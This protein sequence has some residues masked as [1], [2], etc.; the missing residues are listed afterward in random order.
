MEIILVVMLIGIVSAVAIA[1]F[2]EI[3]KTRAVARNLTS[4]IRYA[5]EL[6][7]RLQTNC[8]VYFFSTTEYRV[9][10]NDSTGDLVKDPHTGA[11]FVV[12][13]DGQVSGVT[14]THDLG[15]AN[16]V[17]FNSLGT[18]LDGAGTPLAAAATITVSGTGGDRTV[19][20]E[21]NTGKVTGP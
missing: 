15:A 6:A 3:P 14:I 9:F 21:P 19:T 4:D 10:R 18:P 5:K 12:T 2:P 13:L 20:V 1:R 7:N 11:N 8:G 17:K 16:V